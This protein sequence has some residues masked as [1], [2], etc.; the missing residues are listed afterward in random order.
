MR[1]DGRRARIMAAVTEKDTAAGAGELMTRLCRFAVDEM[2]LSGCALVLMSGAESVSMLAGAG[3]HASTITGLQMELGEGPCLQAR[4]SGVPVFLPDLAAGDANRWPAFA[5]A[6]LAVGV[7]AEFSLPLT[8][9]PGGIGTLD[10]CRDRPGMLSEEHLADALVTADIARDAVLHQQYAPGGGGVAELLDMGADRIVIHQATGMIAAQLNDT[11]S[12]TW[13]DKTL[14]CSG[15]LRRVGGNVSGARNDVMC[16][17][18]GRTALS[19]GI[20][21]L[22]ADAGQ[23]DRRAVALDG[24]GKTAARRRGHERKRA[25]RGG[26]RPA[27]TDASSPPRLPAVPAPHAALAVCTASTAPRSRAVGEIGR[28]SRPRV[29][30]PARP[31][32]GCAPG[33]RV[34]LRAARGVEL[35]LDGTEVQVRRPRAGKPGRR[36]FVSGKKKQ[37]TKKATVVTDEEGRTLWAGRFARGGCM[38]RPRCGPRASPTCS[39]SIPRSR[40][41]STPG[42][43]AWPRSSRIR[44]R[45][46]R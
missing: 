25:G 31:A 29:R 12:T 17:Q 2:A 37:N 20:Y 8:A 39:R 43:A 42:T 38:T 23:A 9:G 30:V 22:A 1:D 27:F 45:P 46:R 7:H 32:C 4:A 13:W 3:R 28:C 41:K 16:R 5:A 26:P 34:R 19:H 14:G 24:A 40:P 36:A 33:R 11:T 35:R 15:C 6:A 18:D 10:L 21:G 44:S